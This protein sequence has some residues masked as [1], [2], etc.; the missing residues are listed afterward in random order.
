M[1]KI[2]QTKGIYR[3]GRV[4]WITYMG[5]DGKQKYE[6]TGSDL[7]ANAE[8]LLAQRR[9][10]VDA[11]KEPETSR[12]KNN[13]TFSELAERYRP[14]VINQKGASI[15]AVYIRQLVAE[16]GAIKLNNFSL[17]LIEGWQ[18]RRLHTPRP[19]QKEGGSPLPPV[20]PA[21]VNRQLACLKHMFTKALDWEMVNEA[22]LKRVRKTK[23]FAENNQR[24]RYLSIEDCQALIAACDSHLKPIVIFAI[25]TGC[26][27][28]EI[29]GLTWDRVDLKHGFILLDDTKSGKR[30]EI[31]INQTLYKT[32]HGI[33]RRLDIPFVFW[34]P[35]TGDRYRDI[36]ESFKTACH[37]T[38][39]EDFHFHDLRHTFASQ[40]IMAGVDITTVSKLLGH[41][42]LTMTLRYSH[43]APSHLQSAVEKL[44]KLQSGMLHDNS[45]DSRGVK[46]KKGITH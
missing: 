36:S 26:R 24:L 2:R 17:S 34:N 45:H 10:D 43:L 41:T 32:F 11:G 25:N 40:L 42:N 30:R 19:S 46:Q 12:R 23:L 33:I 7:K 5:V 18:A 29:L 15:K 39:I 16:F 38:K 27:R 22:T 35:E 13:F 3:R 20:K 9:L 31:P 21:T 37:R 1:P 6:S 44:S 8:L 4:Y 14:F 28:G